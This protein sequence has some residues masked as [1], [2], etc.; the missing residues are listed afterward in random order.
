MFMCMCVFVC[1]WCLY[2]Y[3]YMFSL[4]VCILSSFPACARAG[5]DRNE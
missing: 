1:M 2:V 5:E 4:V 3:M